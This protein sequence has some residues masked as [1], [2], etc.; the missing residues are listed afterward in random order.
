MTR[1]R[2]EVIAP[3]LSK[4]LKELDSKQLRALKLAGCRYVL[5][6]LTQP[7]DDFLSQSIAQLMETGR[8]S[9]DAREKLEDMAY[10]F[11]EKY[12]PLYEAN[13][14]NKEAYKPFFNQARIINAISFAGKD[15]SYLS[16]IES[17]YEAAQAAAG[18][19]RKAFLDYIESLTGTTAA[20]NN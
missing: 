15:D 9:A 14:E 3:R 1:E 17:L 10:S 12:Y 11:D 5:P 7:W 20:Q 2:L 19:D 13:P 8:L 6:L 18:H 4:I 16:A